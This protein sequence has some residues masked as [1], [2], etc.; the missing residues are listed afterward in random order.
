MHFSLSV[1]VVA[2]NCIITQI[3]VPAGLL[4]SAIAAMSKAVPSCNLYTLSPS[5]RI[6]NE[7]IER[8]IDI[9][10]IDTTVNVRTL[11][12][13]DEMRYEANVGT[14]LFR[15]YLDAQFGKDTLLS[16]L[17]VGSGFGGP[18]R[19]LAV[20]RPNITKI[21]AL[22][23]VPEISELAQVLTERTIVAD[24][25]THVTGDVCG[26]LPLPNFHAAQGVLALLHMPDLDGA[27]SSICQHLQPNGIMYIEDF[28]RDTTA[29]DISDKSLKCLTDVV[30]CP[31]GAPLTREEWIATLKGAGFQGKIEFH[32]VTDAWRPWVHERRLAYVHHMDRHI[33]VHGEEPA[34]HML[35]FYE[36]M[37]A[38]FSTELRGCRILAHKT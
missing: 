16:V 37:D 13:V 26:S 1:A 21:V 28:C 7:L 27:L 29:G 19:L 35:E 12:E 8:G 14:D 30:G 32:D 24:S 36:M 38:L 18:S 4:Y 15:S 3:I 5:Q 6:R 33:R 23:L 11:N 25:I 34:N 10:Q 20:T 2:S 9:D 22:E 31:R 17:D